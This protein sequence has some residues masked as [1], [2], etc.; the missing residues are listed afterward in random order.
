MR[1]R[2]SREWPRM[3]LPW[4]RNIRRNTITSTSGLERVRLKPRQ[5]WWDT[6][7]VMFLSMLW[8]TQNI[9]HICKYM[10][11]G[12]L[13]FLIAASPSMRGACECACACACA[14]SPVCVCVRTLLAQG[15]VPTTVCCE[16]NSDAC[17]SIYSMQ[18]GRGDLKSFAQRSSLQTSQEA[19]VDH[20]CVPAPNQSELLISV[21]VQCCTSC[22]T[23]FPL[24]QFRILLIWPFRPSDLNSDFEEHSLW[25]QL[26]ISKP[27]QCV[28]VYVYVCVC[29][30]VCVC[31][32]C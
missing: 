15:M 24:T 8:H 17:N 30:C 7:C 11:T 2:E 27:V 25:N 19:R 28:C 29:A 5:S 3:Q 16:A 6:L 32:T 26:Q 1:S 21:P 18:G 20:R 31:E 22:C 13:Y 23:V 10:G 12:Q 4:L 9:G 14:W